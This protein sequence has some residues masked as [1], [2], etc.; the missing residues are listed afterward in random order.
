MK[1]IFLLT[2]VILVALILA[3]SCNNNNKEPESKT[4][5][6]VFDSDNG[7]PF[8]T[9]EIKEGE[10][11]EAPPVP[12]KTGYT[13]KEW[14]LN[15]EAYD[16]KSLVTSDVLL[17]AVWTINKY[18]VT[19]DTDGGNP[20]TY[21]TQE[22][23]YGSKAKDPGTPSMYSANF[24]GWLYDDEKEFSFDTEITRD[25]ELKAKWSYSIPSITFYD[26]IFNVDGDTTIVPSQS[27]RNRT[28]ASKPAKDPVSN[29]KLFKFWSEQKN[30]DTEFNFETAAITS[31]KT[32]YAV[33]ED[34]IYHVGG[35]GPAG[36]YIFYDCD[37]DNSDGNSDGLISSICGWRYLE[38]AP[39]DLK[40]T[41]KFG[42]YK[43]NDTT[44]ANIGTYQEI[45]KGKEN[46]EA[47]LRVLTGAE[48]AVINCKCYSIVV[49]GKT[50]NDWF[51]PSIDELDKMYFVL[52]KANISSFA[53]EDPLFY[54]SST[55][56]AEAYLA[57]NRSFYVSTNSALPDGSKSNGN[58]DS[59]TCRVRPVRRF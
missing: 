58:R 32:L 33:W 34:D 26:V 38:A 45:G 53:D 46:T 24:G 12:L 16:F 25:Y 5:I 43:V 27:V 30:G 28:Y 48:T 47:L 9:Q 2:A 19:F 41:Y 54:W 7:S 1:R 52:R 50:Y 51:L 56:Q 44:Y 21:Q 36:G 18:K 57:L 49:D 55:E 22:I 37:A 29:Y 35:R 13:F 39:G 8:E 4:Y 14:Q 17:K 40:G 31:D 3:V 23:E 10:R 20:A 15:G 11:V 6:V 42:A 59:S